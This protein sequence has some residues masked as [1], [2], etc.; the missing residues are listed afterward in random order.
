MRISSLDSLRGLAALTVVVHHCLHVFA[1]YDRPP[2]NF[3]SEEFWTNPFSLFKYTPL[4]ITAIG[5]TAVLIFFVLSGFV[6][7]LALQGGRDSYS[8]FMIKRV[9]RIYPPF[10]ASILLSAFL[11]SLVAH[12]VM[13]GTSEWFTEASW[14][15]P[16]SIS[17]VL[18]HLAMV[19]V[20]PYTE[21]NNVM[22]SLVH[23]LRISLIF[24][25]IVALVRMD[26]KKTVAAFAAV[27][28][29]AHFLTY[30]SPP[31]LSSWL[32]TVR[33]IVLFSA[34]AA[35]ALNRDRVNEIIGGMT[36]LQ[37][38]VAWLGTLALLWIP[39]ANKSTIYFAGPAAVAI[40]A[41]CSADRVAAVALAKPLP[42]YLGRISYSLYLVHL[43]IILFTVYALH[44]I[45]PLW[46]AVLSGGIAAFPAAA[47]A[48][49]LVE[50]PSHSLA[51]ALT[52]S[53]SSAV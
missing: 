5:F 19:H 38:A 14:A 1:G 11:Y 8:T 39:I 4:H 32:E 49:R 52:R 47:I 23:E 29:F 6:L 46:V 30:F 12:R 51:K 18:G 40:V 31:V 13:P 10:A 22:W 36:G 3:T 44:G 42:L 53:R 33:Y 41:L 9:A 45:V 50:L 25:L 15:V 24:P 17:L 26:A 2:I 16:P 21:L 7:A 27:S 48:Y 34:G 20:P 28:V 37:R 35:L 43:P